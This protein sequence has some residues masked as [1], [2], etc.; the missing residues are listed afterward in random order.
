MT[1]QTNCPDCGVEIGQ[2]HCGDCDIERCSV[3]GQQR[4]TCDCKGHD[5]L[6]S[7]WTGEWPEQDEITAVTV[8]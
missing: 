5:A 3:C 4:L 8:V 6:K 7:V 2:P 1:I